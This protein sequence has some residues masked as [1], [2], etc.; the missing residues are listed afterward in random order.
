MSRFLSRIAT[1]DMQHGL[2][3]EWQLKIVNPFI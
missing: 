3:I 1:E 2:E